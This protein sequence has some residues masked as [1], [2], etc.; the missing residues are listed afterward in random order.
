MLLAHIH[1]PYAWQAD[2]D[3]TVVIPV[4][5]LLYLFAVGRLGAPRAEA[6]S[7]GRSAGKG[8]GGQ[9]V[10][11]VRARCGGSDGEMGGMR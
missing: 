3:T 5:A 9:A 1:S 11:L 4:L 8:A 7:A 2:V 10:P 6:R